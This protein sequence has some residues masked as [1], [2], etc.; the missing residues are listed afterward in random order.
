MMVI[1]NLSFQGLDYLK[2]FLQNW[3]SD[4]ELS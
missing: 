2:P 4:G 1:T 3:P